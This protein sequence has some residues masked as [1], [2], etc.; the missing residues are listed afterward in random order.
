MSINRTYLTF[1]VLLCTVL[2]T[3]C[4]VN[5]EPDGLLEADLVVVNGKIFTSNPEQPW[6]ESFA[7]K[8]RQFVYVGDT[9]EEFAVASD[10]VIDLGG[11]LVIPGLIDA[12]AHPGYVNVEQFG[13]VS[14]ETPEALLASVRDY[15]E[16]HPDKDWLRLCCWPTAMFVSAGDGPKKEMLDAVLPDRL[17]WFESD[18]AHDYWLNSKAMVRLGIDRNTPDPKPGV[19]MYARDKN[20]DPTGWVKEGAGVQHFAKEF[21]LEEDEEIQRHKNSVEQ[22]LQILSNHGVTALF[23]AGNKGYG[24]LTYA[25]IAELEREG[26]LPI[27]YFGTYQIFVPSRANEAIE[28][29]QRYR[30]EYGGQLLQFRSVKLFMDGITA[31]QSASYSEPYSGSDDV[32]GTL[33]SVEEIHG[34]LLDLHEAK[35]DLHVHAIGDLA[36]NRVLD[37]VERAQ[38]TVVGEFY[39]RVTVAHLSLVKPDDIQRIKELG[40]IANFSPWWLGGVVND[41]SETLLGRE[42]YNR[43]YS[44]RSIFETGATVTF[45]SDEWWGGEMLA[46]YISPY[47]GIQVGHTRQY[48][49]DWWETENDG[50]KLPEDERLALEQLLVGYTKNGA[51]Q[52]RME[53]QLG[54]IQIGMLADFVVLDADLFAIESDRIASLKPRVV[55]MEGK[56]IQGSF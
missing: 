38:N 13:Y 18:T 1:A 3:G 20:G 29:I 31:N 8:D 36:V 35:L 25:L 53:E 15:A 45:S 6:A 5:Q 17:L 41:R 9:I 32:V 50:I 23:D 42:R 47:L 28:E 11:Q 43:M 10:T 33:L 12:H 14:G 2:L 26:R 46:T 34:L 51:Y 48:P 56:V 49:Q 21:A 27:R 40:V 7:I 24:D 22:T 39:P 54:S 52:L 30:R 16:R 37:A 4:H 44:P 19:A 55:V